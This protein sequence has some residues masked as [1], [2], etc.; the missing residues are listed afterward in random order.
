MRACVQAGVTS[1]LT[2]YLG[3]YLPISA[4]Y[5]PIGAAA[6]VAL[7]ATVTFPPNNQLAKSVGGPIRKRKY[8]PQLSG[9]CGAGPA[10]R[11]RCVSASCGAPAR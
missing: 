4:S 5:A 6:G 3:P 8:A 9:T 11:P 7:A 1:A 10:C 2:A